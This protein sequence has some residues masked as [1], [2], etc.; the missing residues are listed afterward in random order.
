MSAG[1]LL[2][3]TGRVA[4][5]PGSSVSQGEPGK[6][7]IPV[8]KHLITDADLGGR[9]DHRKPLDINHIVKL[10]EDPYSCNLYERH[11]HA[12]KKLVKHY[13]HGFPLKDLIQVF[14]ILNLCAEKVKDH[15]EYAQSI[16]DIL[17]LCGLPFLKK[18]LSDEANY[19]QIVSESFSQMGYLMRVPDTKVKM[20]VCDSIINVYN[21][22]PPEQQIE[23]CQRISTTYNLQM[24]EQS[25]VA[26]TLVL[27]LTLLE[28]QLDV[29]LRVLE[30]LQLLSSSS[31][32]N[33][34]LMLK[35]Q[36]ATKICS[37][38]NDPDPSGQLLFRSSNILWNLLEKGLKE[39]IVNQLSNLECIQTLKEVF[40]NQLLN[41][42]RHYDRQ[43]RNDLLVIATLIAEN[44][45]APMVES[46]FAN[47]LILFAT[48]SEVK[49]RSPLVR[50]IT[51]TFNNEDF[52]LKKLLF[53]M[54]VVFSKDLCSIQLL[55]EHKVLLALFHYVKPNEEREGKRWSAAHYEELQLQ[56]LATL[57]TV[58]PLLVEDYMTC[59]GNT[60]LLLFLEWCVSQDP[61]FGRGNCF[62]ATGGYGNKCPQ[63]RHCL[64]LLRSVVSL[65][66]EA[67]N[68]DLCDQGAINQLLD[69]L[70][71]IICSSEEENEFLLEIQT[72]ILI[73]LS[74]ICENDLHRKELFGSEGVVL[75][76][77]FLKIDTNKIYSGLGHNKLILAAIDCIWSCVVGCYVLED[78][79]FEREGIFLLLDLLMT[80]PKNTH[81]LILG[82]LL[83]FCENPKAI[84]HI[85]VW[86]G[87]TDQTAASLFIELWR[88]EEEEM[89]VQ[90]DEYGR[91]VDLKK[92][93]VGQFQ[94][95]Q[96]VIPLPA[97]Y[98]SAAVMD[99]S[100]N[101]RAKI[102][103][104]FCRLGFEDLPGLSTRDY[105]TLAVISRYLDF[106]VGEIW[107]EIETELKEEGVRPIS[108]DLEALHS[109]SKLSEH[110]SK[111]VAALQA[112]MLESQQQQ[113]LQEETQMYTE[114]KAN[115]KQRNL[116]IQSWKNYLART[117]DCEAM[118]EAKELQKRFIESSR[119]DIR[120]EDA[121]FHSTLIN[122]LQT[123]SACGRMVT[124]KSTPTFL[125]G[126]PLANTDLAL[127]KASI[128]GGALIQTKAAKDLKRIQIG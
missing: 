48:F 14:K 96:G 35:A 83:E 77:T 97:S 55:S 67:V 19:T 51:H 82:I 22:K 62:H 2:L 7:R 93:L 56:A 42:Y 13:H 53:N 38:L 4:P 47:Q 111:K 115:H 18:R 36:A 84:S 100:E 44:P 45:R 27:S 39:E 6:K 98:P 58:A 16:C 113:D 31:E 23:D 75:V 26:E 59:Q 107:H 21:P 66:H 20:Q 99:I 12:L 118:R 122:N 8:I 3:R 78:L 71:S 109:V 103:S 11:L 123:T 30:V 65:G 114:I 112:E 68:Q 121:L 89:G 101:M 37:C 81:N 116:A 15:A 49:S 126:G 124:V 105:V 125:I 54:I 63:M 119:P 25:G 32:I 104:I 50:S 74:T 90:R 57:T 80:C 60:R 61:Y 106:K 28:N 79:F 86:R 24:I 64:R 73:I 128:R 94:E 17:K 76:M 87:K 85:N 1:E 117:S 120:K 72:D 110:T 95:E 34:N 92:P 91:I 102:Y 29:K 10:L 127:E 88:Q 41:G 5:M 108:P 69:V 70:N 9:E 33:C 46:G 40:L 43:L 52:E